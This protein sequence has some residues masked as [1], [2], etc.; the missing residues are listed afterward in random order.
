MKKLLIFAAISI[1]ALALVVIFTRNV[2]IRASVEKGVKMVTGLTLRMD[3]FRVG[4]FKP[5][6]HI[7]G[8]KLFSPAGFKDRMM[9]DMP[10]IYVDYDRRALLRGKVHLINARIDLKELI[11]VRNAYG[12]LNLDS[13]K[14]VQARKRGARPA[15]RMPPFMIDRLALKIGKV[16]FKDYS[17]GTP[18]VKEFNLAI[19]ETYTNI[20]DPN[21]LVSL[22]VVRAIERTSIAA[23][24]NFNIYDLRGSVQG[25]LANAQQFSGMTG[26]TTQKAS[27]AVETISDTLTS[28][29]GKKK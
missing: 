8:L 27:Q 12:E 28:I 1:V 3:S 13:L 21:A 25:I 29:F 2:I 19:D 20:D 11:V 9:V 18:I 5:F 6:L 7:R 24:A 17:M 10:E 15:E 22:I 26:D 4:I 23:L 14:V 16:V